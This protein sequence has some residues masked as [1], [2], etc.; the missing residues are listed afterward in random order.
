MNAPVWGCNPDGLPADRGST[1]GHF[2]H[3]ALQ[4]EVRDLGEEGLALRSEVELN[5]RR[6]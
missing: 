2:V 4:A 5:L 1:R 3:K 6:V